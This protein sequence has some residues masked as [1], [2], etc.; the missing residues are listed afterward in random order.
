MNIAADTARVAEIEAQ[1]AD[2]IRPSWKKTAV[3]LGIVAIGFVYLVYLFFYFD[4]GN[5]ANRWNSERAALFAVDTYAHKIHADTRWKDTGK[6]VVTLEGSRF[7]KYDEKPAWV[8]E[9]AEK[10]HLIDMGDD[11]EILVAPDHVL[12]TFLGNA[13]IRVDRPVDGKLA[14]M[15]E[16]PLPE[17]IRVTKNK[18]EVR[19][20]NFSR[21]QISKT[22]V[23]V[24][25]YF[26]G[27][28]HFWF[29][30]NSPLANHSVAD[31]VGSWF[32]G[33]QISDKMSNFSLTFH[34]WW[35]NTMWL[36][37]D[38]WWALLDTLFMAVMGTALAAFLGLPLA[39][40]AAANLNPIA[41]MRFALRRLFDAL[42]GIDM[43]IWSLIFIRAFGMGPF[44]GLLAIAITDTGTLGKLMSEAIENIDKKPVE[45]VQSTGA[46]PVQRHRFGIVPQIMPL[47]ISQTLYYLE[48]NTR[49]AVIIGAMGAGGIGLQFL[50]AMR[51][52]NSWENVA[53]ISIIVLATVMLMDMMSAK[54]RR[55][56]IGTQR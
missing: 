52:G 56:L 4:I 47:F 26:Y 18:V 54:L 16:A 24:F 9:T 7:E 8:R 35:N 21:V 20:T 12:M 14:A 13:P 10:T 31:A 2:N 41:P 22:K 34:E 39:F 44:S 5:I 36:H 40:L 50:G 3:P 33:P 23:R 38:V 51:T 15:S 37:R 27:W 32:E 48:S 55:K 25:R 42:R 49:G 6:Y 28:E 11:G 17:W 45:G 46:R 29:D 1:Y 53:Y 30:F 43:L 19:P